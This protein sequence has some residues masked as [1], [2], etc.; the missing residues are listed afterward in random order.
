MSEV[1]SYKTISSSTHEGYGNEDQ[2]N[3]PEKPEDTHQ[4]AEENSPTFK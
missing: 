3:A 1:L 2:H 4:E